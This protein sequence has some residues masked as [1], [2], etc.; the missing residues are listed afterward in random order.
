LRKDKVASQSDVYQIKKFKLN[1]L[2]NGLIFDE[3][4]HLEIKK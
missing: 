2:E 4:L 3:D 1:E